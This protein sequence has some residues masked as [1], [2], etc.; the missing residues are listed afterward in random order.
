MEKKNLIY[1][2]Q[3]EK[4]ALAKVIDGITAVATSDKKD[5]IYS[6]NRV[7]KGIISG[8][9]L[10]EIQKEW[11]YYCSKGKIDLKYEKS[12][13]Y[14]NS[15]TELIDYLDSD[16]S[17]DEIA[18]ALKKL[19]FIPAFSNINAEDEML[20]IEYMKIIRRL[21]AGELSVLFCTYKNKDIK[22]SGASEWLKVIAEKSTLKYSELVEIHEAK[23]IEFHLITDRTF[24]DRSGIHNI[25]FRLTNLGYNIC[26]YIELYDEYVKNVI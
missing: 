20:T 7:L 25:N 8:K 3:S 17:N 4:N 11:D 24:S 18:Q 1:V 5:I 6:A 16:I 26:K 19:F 23:L 22:I 14:M 2:E 15:L 21:N 10:Y 13:L 12:T 9:F